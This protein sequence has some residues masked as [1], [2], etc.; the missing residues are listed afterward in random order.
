[1]VCMFISICFSFQLEFDQTLAFLIQ[2]ISSGVNDFISVP[3]IRILTRAKQTKRRYI[4]GKSLTSASNRRIVRREH[5]QQRN[6]T[7][8]NCKARTGYWCRIIFAHKPNINADRLW[9]AFRSRQ[10]WSA[11]WSRAHVRGIV[12]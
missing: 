11:S 6:G 8:Q 3:L 5:E 4:T 1:M 9:A 12:R 10:N 2:H 7:D